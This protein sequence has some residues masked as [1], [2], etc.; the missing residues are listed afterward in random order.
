MMVNNFYGK[1]FCYHRD[2]SIKIGEPYFKRLIFQFLHYDKITTENLHCAI[3]SI[4]LPEP[5]MYMYYSLR[6][7][8]NMIVSWMM[9]SRVTLE[10]N[11][12]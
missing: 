1:I 2:F 11:Q 7:P 6:T 3:V 5:S 10:E 9:M 8:V 12:I 4:N